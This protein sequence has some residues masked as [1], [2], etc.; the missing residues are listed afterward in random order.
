MSNFQLR[1][2]V[3]VP[4]TQRG[5]PKAGYPFDSMGV[6]ENSFFHVALQDGD[7]KEKMIDRIKGAAARWR[8]ADESRKDVKFTVAETVLPDDPMGVAVIGVWRTA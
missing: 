5:A 7:S 8:K 2:N 6:A 4:T 3:P 1:S